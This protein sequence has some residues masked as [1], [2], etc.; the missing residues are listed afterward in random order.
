MIE[1]AAEAIGYYEGFAERYDALASEFHW[2]SP[3]VMFG[4]MFDYVKSG[5][6]L[7][8]V[9]IGTGLSSAMFAKVGLEI[10]GVDGSKEMLNRCH[11]KNLAKY[12]QCSDISSKTFDFADGFFDCAISNGVFYFIERLEHTVSEVSRCLKPGGYFSFNIECTNK[13]IIDIFNNDAN[14]EIY[15]DV[16]EKTGVITYRHSLEYIDIVVK[17]SGLSKIDSLEYYAYTSPS[18]GRDVYFNLITCRKT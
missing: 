13:N 1:N 8:D 7:L 18:T 9:G 10:Y 4:M 11:S 16:K 6:K 12:L 5:E 15:K 14:S 3:R 17:N 2:Y